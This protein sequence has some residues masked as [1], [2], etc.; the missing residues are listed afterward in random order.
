MALGITNDGTMT[1]YTIPL[2]GGDDP[3]WQDNSWLIEHLHQLAQH[4]E[5]SRMKI[6]SIGTETVNATGA[7]PKLV[8]KGYENYIQAYYETEKTPLRLIR[9]VDFDRMGNREKWD[10]WD[11][12]LKVKWVCNRCH[13]AHETND[14]NY[15]SG[16]REDIGHTMDVIECGWC[17][18]TL[19]H[20]TNGGQSDPFNWTFKNK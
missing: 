18:N 15:W 20:R 17:G 12:I 3:D 16:K 11:K 6:I 1:V 14:N 13:K 9:A 4:I 10:I 19:T 8:V 7:I 2:M 5:E